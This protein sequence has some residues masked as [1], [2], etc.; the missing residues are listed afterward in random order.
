VRFIRTDSQEIVYD[1]IR[2]NNSQNKVTASDF[3]ST[4]AIQRRLKEDMVKISGAEY[5]GG[6]RGGPTDAIKRRPNLLA[7]YTVGQALA[8]LHGD[9]TVAY[10]QRTEIWSSDALYAKYFN[11][12]T[13]AAHIVFAYSLLRAVEARKIELL[14]KSKNEAGTMTSSEEDQLKFFRRR[15][16]IFLFVA[17]VAS[18]LEIFCL[19]KIPNIFRVSFGSK[20]SPQKAQQIWSDVVE[21]VVPLSVHLEDAFTFGLQN[22]ER[23]R[24][25]I[26]KFRSLVEAT[27]S[28][29]KVTYRKFA[30]AITLK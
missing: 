28:A 4:D 10:N 23:V 21:R 16:S 17:A 19:K 18:S 27:S 12:H 29:N 14:N 1:I 30:K 25:A 3:R 13:T 15:G 5:E 24:S 20:T 11:D 22:Q 9:A 8:A 7:S 6:R 2:Y 26:Q